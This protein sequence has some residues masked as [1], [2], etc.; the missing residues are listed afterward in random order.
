MATK[1]KGNAA[2]QEAAAPAPT[3]AVEN[4]AP[5]AK[6]KISAKA[7][8][9]VRIAKEKAQKEP[10]RLTG[11]LTMIAL[12][13]YNHWRQ[14]VNFGIN[15]ED[16]T[17]LPLATFRKAE[18]ALKHRTKDGEIVDT[19]WGGYIAVPPANVEVVTQLLNDFTA[20]QSAKPEG[21]RELGIALWE[22]LE[23][24]FTVEPSPRKP[25]AKK[26]KAETTEAVAETATETTE[27]TEVATEVAEV[28]EA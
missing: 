14:F 23:T 19:K 28:A 12:V 17:V 16:E 3:A 15:G 7:L 21:E 20:A 27:A 10:K 2:A 1:T 5:V 25:R 24:P 9:K 26:V 18:G 4:T 8:P 22:M 6:F 11:P 13:S